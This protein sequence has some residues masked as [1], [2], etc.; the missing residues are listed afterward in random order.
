MSEFLLQVPLWICEV[1]L[2]FSCY[3]IIMQ[4]WLAFICSTVCV[5]FFESFTGCFGAESWILYS[6]WIM[7]G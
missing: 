5:Y 4:C 2:M 3:E 6:L 7:V 1:H